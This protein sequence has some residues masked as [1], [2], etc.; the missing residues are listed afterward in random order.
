MSRKSKLRRR[1]ERKKRQ[2]QN[3][4]TALFLRPGISAAKLFEALEQQ[5]HVLR[6]VLTESQQQS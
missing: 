5:L 4:R 2:H 6:H 3:K 1:R